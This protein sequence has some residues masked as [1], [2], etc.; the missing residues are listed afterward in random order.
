MEET[1][2]GQGGYAKEMGEDFLRRQREIVARHV[3]NADVVITTAQIPGKRAPLLVPQDMVES[4]R[5]GS[6]ILD[7]A[8]TSG[9]NCALSRADAEVIH[10][11]VRILAPAN[12]A[13]TM[14][15]DASLLYARNLQALLQEVVVDGQVSIDPENDVVGPALLTYEGTVHHARTAELLA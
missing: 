1:G 8:V 9:G 12:I 14:P 5:A 10:G 6:V 13:S 2:E 15:R 11:G 7:L 4:M 3:A